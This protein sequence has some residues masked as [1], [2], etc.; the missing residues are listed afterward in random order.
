MSLVTAKDP[1]LRTFHWVA[2]ENGIAHVEFPIAPSTQVSIEIGCGVGWHSISYS[3]SNPNETL[4]AIEKT[5][6]KFDRFKRR[7]ETHLRSG[8]GIGHGL[9]AIHA[10]ATRCLPAVLERMKAIDCKIRNVFFLYPNPEPKAASKRWIRMPFLDVI[11][12]ACDSDSRI[13]FATNEPTYANEIVS[14]APRRGLEIVSHERF[15]Q[16][17]RPSF[18]PRTH[19]EL[20]YYR[21]GDTL[22]LLTLNRHRIISHQKIEDHSP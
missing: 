14:W 6:T 4:L 16:S 17:T 21:R 2:P 10:D 13:H 7:L 9:V 18:Q 19:F 1:A 11:V 12:D 3:R 15:S 5:A 20:K 22:N 8:V